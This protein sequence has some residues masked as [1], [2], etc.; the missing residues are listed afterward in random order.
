[1]S[2]QAFS[3][4]YVSTFFEKCGCTLLSYYTNSNAKLE[5]ICSCGNRA[6]IRFKHFSKGHRCRLCGTRRGGQKHSGQNH[7]CWQPDREQLAQRRQLRIKAK[8]ILDNA[9]A[10]LKV[11]IGGGHSEQLGYS[12][13]EL[14]DHLCSFAQFEQLQKSNWH[15][16]HI[17]PLSAFSDHGITDLQVINA[18]SNLR[19]LSAFDNISKNDDYD[20]EEFMAYCQKQHVACGSNHERN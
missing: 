4:L 15:I 8:S 14:W 17:F 16:D 9:K 5:C 11:K 12:D 1:M 20:E 3:H 2:N 6:I 10:R 18:L 13:Q 7:E 19:P